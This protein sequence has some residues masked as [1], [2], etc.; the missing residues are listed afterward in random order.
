MSSNLSHPWHLTPMV[1]VFARTSP[2]I[3]SLSE[4]RQR[5]VSRNPGLPFFIR[6]GETVASRAPSL[7][8]SETASARSS[9]V[10]SSTSQSICVTLGRSS[11]A[12]PMNALRTS[13]TPS[14]P[15]EPI[16]APTL[17]TVIAGM[18]P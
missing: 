17:L 16:P 8:S 13:G 11:S 15:L 14:G 2:A 18:R 10:M 6:T 4:S 1:E 5:Q 7:R 9:G 12:S 3:L